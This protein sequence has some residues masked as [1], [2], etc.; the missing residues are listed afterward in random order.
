MLNSFWDNFL[1]IE[2]I[3]IVE[4]LKGEQDMDNSVLLTIKC[5]RRE[6]Q[7]TEKDVFLDNGACVM[8][9]SQ[10]G[11]F[12]DWHYASVVLPQREIKR[13]NKFEKKQ[14]AHNNG[15]SIQIFSLKNN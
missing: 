10:K 15:K 5:G 2:N 9:L 7:I 11:P 8:L 1:K 14:K 4:G 3:N 13:I 6:Y 12:K